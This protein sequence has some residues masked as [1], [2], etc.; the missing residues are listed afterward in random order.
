MK[1]EKLEKFIKD[2]L[3]ELG[4]V[5]NKNGEYQYKD[6]NIWNFYIMDDETCIIQYCDDKCDDISIISY[7][8]SFITDMKKTEIKERLKFIKD[9]QGELHNG[10]W[11][12]W[13]DG[14]S[15]IKEYKND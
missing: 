12:I 10:N 3:L 6:I 13:V 8:T 14:Y 1:V 4:F 7:S 15:M 9:M 2:E 5:K 11:C